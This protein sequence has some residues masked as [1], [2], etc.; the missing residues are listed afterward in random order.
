M[1]VLSDEI[2]NDPTGKGYAA[3][4]PDQPGHVVALLNALTETKHKARMITARGILS[5][6]PGGPVAAALVLDKL[7]AA[8]PSVPAL[9]WAFGFLKTA[10]GLDIGHP[11]THGM[12]DQLTPGVITT[13]EADNLKSLS[14]QSAS[15]AEVLGLPY[16]T[17]EMLRNR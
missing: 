10:E 12:I 4:L 7:E 17:E 11:A 3:F 14:L 15:R 6:Y 2:D 1:S 5:D 13:E 16:V 9:K 8:A